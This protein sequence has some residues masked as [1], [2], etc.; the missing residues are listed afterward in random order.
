MRQQLN[1][2]LS[3]VGQVVKVPSDSVPVKVKKLKVIMAIE[4]PRGQL[5]LYEAD[6]LKLQLKI[7][8]AFM[9]FCN[10]MD[11]IDSQS[12]EVPGTNC[13]LPDV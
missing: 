11:E 7:I 6:S 2:S 4:H 13:H 1:L 3:S 10:Y 9:A 12:L 5:Y 8:N